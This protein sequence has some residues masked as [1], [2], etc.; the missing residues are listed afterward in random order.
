MRLIVEGSPDLE[1]DTFSK[2]IISNDRTGA[3]KYREQRKLREAAE[4]RLNSIENTVSEIMTDVAEI[5]TML[6]LLLNKDRNQ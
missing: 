6:L 4:T 3:E 2:A 1:R 5:R